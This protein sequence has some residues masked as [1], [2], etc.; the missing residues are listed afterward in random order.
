MNNILKSV[1]LLIAYLHSTTGYSAMVN[2]QDSNQVSYTYSSSTPEVHTPRLYSERYLTDRT[3]S[4]LYLARGRHAFDACKYEDAI[5][6]YEKAF[7]LYPL[8][9]EALQGIALVFAQTDRLEEALLYL[10]QAID[11]D[12]FDADAYYL[13]A[14]ILKTQG[15]LHQADEDYKIALYLSPKAEEMF[16]K[17]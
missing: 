7:A 12:P 8:E 9:G 13:R 4:S 6:H 3:A 14:H 2:E 1:F 17:K 11:V 16:S 10:N 5:Q 15:H